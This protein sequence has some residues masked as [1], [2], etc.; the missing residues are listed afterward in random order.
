MGFLPKPQRTMTESPRCVVI[1]RG[2]YSRRI[3]VSDDAK[4]TERVRTG[5][6]CEGVSERSVA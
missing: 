5:R 2:L 1:H 3:E 4:E 6:R